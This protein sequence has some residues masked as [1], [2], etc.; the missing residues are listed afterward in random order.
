MEI[1]DTP[2][3]TQKNFDTKRILK[4]RRQS[5]DA[6]FPMR[7]KF[8]YQKVFELQESSSKKISGPARKKIP[9]K[10]MPL[11]SYPQKIFG[12]RNVLKH[13]SIPS[14]YFAALWDKKF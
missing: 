7:R 6:A 5:R 11:P 10:L 12:T 13:I 14:L 3:L 4:D 2:P 1:G 9:K 8:R